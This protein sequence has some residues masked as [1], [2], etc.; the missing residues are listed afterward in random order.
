MDYSFIVKVVVASLQQVK[1]SISLSYDVTVNTHCEESLHLSHIIQG[2]RKHEYFTT[3]TESSHKS[4]NNN[5]TLSG[6]VLKNL[7]LILILCVF[8]PMLYNPPS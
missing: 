6:L 4:Q 3:K 5:K 1:C 7:F 8:L 2:V